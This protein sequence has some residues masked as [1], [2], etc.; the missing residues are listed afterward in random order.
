MTHPTSGHLWLRALLLLLALV[1]LAALLAPQVVLGLRAA[2]LDISV[3]RIFSRLALVAA[4]LVLIAYRRSILDRVYLRSMW[5]WD[6]EGRAQLLD[7]IRYS[8]GPLLLLSVLMVVLGARDVL[9]QK[10]D[11][12]LL[13]LPEYLA[14][15]AIIAMLEET[16]FRGILLG[17]FLRFC[18]PAAAIVATSLVFALVHPLNAPDEALF[19]PT[20][21]SGFHALIHL[22]AG[23]GDP[24]VLRHMVGYFIVGAILATAAVN[25]GRLYFS[26]GLH[27][28]WVFF[29]K[30]DGVVLSRNET[31]SSVSFGSNRMVDG[32]LIW[33]FL[34]LVF[35][36]VH[37]ATRRRGGGASGGTQPGNA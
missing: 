37:Q 2:G 10:L 33:F 13:R 22:L 26:M 7:G 29:I 30:A 36:L 32:V 18:R 19:A 35:I 11:R 34:L 24:S 25:T 23:F 14:G 3:S 1:A 20:T 17:L 4:L 21:F 5:R 16:V 28:G 12:G 6:R 9:P 27:F 31:W 8:L 15:A